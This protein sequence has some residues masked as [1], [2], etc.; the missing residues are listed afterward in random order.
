MTGSIS[1][2]CLRDLWLARRTSGHHSDLAD[3]ATVLPDGKHD[4]DIVTFFPLFSSY[5]YH[6]VNDRSAIEF[7]TLTVLR[8]FAD[9][10]VV[11]LELRTTPRALAGESG[12][13]GLS[14]TE[15]VQAVLDTIKK[16]EESNDRMHTRLIL[17]VD[18][19][20]TLAE[21]MEV[22]QLCRRFADQ[23]VVG[24]D[25]CG[26][27]LKGD[28]VALS[29]AFEA[30]R[31]VDGL[32][33]TLHFGEVPHDEAE[34]KV[35]LG[36]KPDRLGHVIHLGHADGE[37]IKS[38]KDRGLGLELCLSCNVHAKMTE[39]GYKGHHFGDW[40]KK[41]ECCLSCGI[42]DSCRETGCF[43]AVCLPS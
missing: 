12:G 18:R 3:P 14:K 43:E 22:V 23:G 34:L 4:F 31:Q 17:S 9:D 19:R 25:L 37:V 33:M 36:W 30:A 39:G 11:Y 7:T 35:L 42:L 21:A 6:L 38:V 10:G 28:M 2:Q 1:R 8:D 5:I 29:P 26:D 13:S 15:Y 20:N 27:P 41:E 16:F 32:G 24:I 40:W